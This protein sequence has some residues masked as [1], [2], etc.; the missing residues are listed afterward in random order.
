MTFFLFPNNTHLKLYIVRYSGA[1]I[2]REP[3]WSV[4]RTR[5]SRL[6]RPVKMWGKVQPCMRMG[7]F[8]ANSVMWCKLGPIKLVRMATASLQNILLERVAYRRCQLLQ[9][10]RKTFALAMTSRCVLFFLFSL[11]YYTN[12]TDHRLTLFKVTVFYIVVVWLND[13]DTVTL[14]EC[15]LLSLL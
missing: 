7:F 9:H 13:R 8:H 2:Q 5:L 6:S 14:K 10:P 4:S 1:T 12:T 3:N 11:S 15:R